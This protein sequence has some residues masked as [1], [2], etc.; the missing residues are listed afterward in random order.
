M[1]NPL[2]R[3]DKIEGLTPR[4][5]IGA[6]LTVGTKGPKGNPTETDRF[7]FKSADSVNIGEQLVKPLH[8]AFAAYN[9]AEPIK[10]QSI[11]GNIV[12]ASRS[13]A[14]Q[15]SLSAQVLGAAWKHF[16]KAHPN[17]LPIC[18][19]DGKKATRLYGIGEDGAEDWR[20]IEC[21]NDL[22]A[23]RQG[24]TKACKPSVRFLFRPRWKDGV[25]LPTPLT[26]LLSHSWHNASRLLGFF[27]HVEQQARQ[28]G[29]EKFSLYGLPFLLTLGSKTKPSAGARFPVLSISPDTDLIAFFLA[30]RE[31]LARMGAGEAQR[32]IP[33]KLTD[34]EQNDPAKI[35]RDFAEIVPGVVPS[36]PGNA[37]EPIEGEIVEPP[38]ESE[39]TDDGRLSVEALHRLR[40]NAAAKGLTETQLESLAG[41]RLEDAPASAELEIL[42]SISTYRAPK[43]RN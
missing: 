33:A 34:P 30:Q 24:A 16:P 26:L 8:P 13:E 25:T 38:A 9:G 29:L 40:S 27:E 31:Q 1:S 12:H 42:R 32:A 4:D 41:G 36:K 6:V 18:T 7:Y 37:T 43:P 23:F 3:Y 20:E 21:P 2:P 17:R 35:A 10:R 19:G 11:S 39:T 14:F 22:C 28:L 15:A 5:P